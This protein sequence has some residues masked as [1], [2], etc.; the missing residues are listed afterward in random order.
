MPSLCILV[1]G[2]PLWPRAG[3]AIIVELSRLR[4]LEGLLK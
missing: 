2:L 3:G 1:W 4:A